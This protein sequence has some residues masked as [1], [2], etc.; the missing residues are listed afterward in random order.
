MIGSGTTSPPT[1]SNYTSSKVQPSLKSKIAQG[2][3]Q[4]NYSFWTKYRN[5]L[6]VRPNHRI[7]VINRRYYVL[8]L[9]RYWSRHAYRGAMAA[10][11]EAF[12]IAG[13][14]IEQNS[15]WTAFSLNCQFDSTAIGSSSL[16]F[17]AARVYEVYFLEAACVESLR[18]T[19][20]LHP[21]PIAAHNCIQKDSIQ[22]LYL[23][24][25]CMIKIEVL[26]Y[27]ELQPT[28]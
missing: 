26:S 27:L 1:G 13:L 25:L 5:I 10:R 12:T 7:A 28:A 22:Q 17:W 9:V 4:Q 21:A 15:S 14:P 19:T 3:G 8:F 18:F 24:G 20:V 6:N 2:P 11:G 23:Q 16:D